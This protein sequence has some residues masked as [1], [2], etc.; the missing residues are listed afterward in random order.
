MLGR[1]YTSASPTR[2]VVTS[3]SSKMVYRINSAS[4]SF[5]SSLRCSPCLVYKRLA[6]LPP[7]SQDLLHIIPSE[8]V[9]F[10]KDLNRSFALF[11]SPITFLSNLSGIAI[12][13][14]R[15]SHLLG[16]G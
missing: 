1:G 2:L 16:I 6:N 14:M 9:L 11:R 5:P 13:T 7:I 15:A 12:T 4:F 10:T 3:A 8:L